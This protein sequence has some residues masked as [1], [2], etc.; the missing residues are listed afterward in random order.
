MTL[1]NAIFQQ[2]SS[3]SDY[4]NNNN[5]I[6]RQQVRNTIRQLQDR[7]VDFSAD[8]G[9]FAEAYVDNN[10]RKNSVNTENSSAVFNINK[11]E[12]SA[13]TDLPIIIIEA[14]SVDVDSFEINDCKCI[15]I[16]TGKW[17]LSC[18]VTS[19]VEKRAK[20]IKTLFYGT[21]GTNP[22]ASSTYI[23]GITAL[24]TNIL[25]DVGKKAIY[26]GI[27][28]SNDEYGEYVETTGTFTNTSTNTDCS[29]WSY[30][31]AGVNSGGNDTIGSSTVNFDGNTINQAH[32]S[33]ASNGNVTSDEMGTDRIADEKDNPVDTMMNLHTDYG[34]N[35]VPV[36]ARAIYLS[37]SD[38]TWVDVESGVSFIIND[39]TDFHASG[40]PLFTSHNES[41][42]ATIEHTLPTKQ[43]LRGSC[44]FKD[45]DTHKVTESTWQ[46]VITKS[47]IDRLIG[48]F[49]LDSHRNHSSSYNRIKIILTYNDSSTVEL[50]TD[51]T[52]SGWINRTLYNPNPNKI[53]ASY[54][55]QI[56]SHYSN[57][58]IEIKNFFEYPRIETQHLFANNMLSSFGTALVEDWE[59]G[60]NIQYKIANDTEDSGWLNYNEISTF[61]PFT[62]EPTKAI[63]KLIPK[64]S[65]P[66]P[67]VP[68]I[69]GFGI[70]N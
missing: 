50:I 5:T 20:I 25:R 39:T 45:Y 52:S 30:C 28:I 9:E 66:T 41:F 49:T 32:P 35:N 21:D 29:V 51:G 22:R 18:T 7:N 23:T 11:Y 10:G 16:G 60:C 13:S 48:G 27:K 8:G 70:V 38:I 67:G 58:Y 46:T 56:Q 26:R 61:T 47:N 44:T 3:S 69:K 62:S 6:L 2:P 43:G 59:E 17:Q 4:N 40:I 57:D 14:E 24:K 31:Y 34:D 36:I 19:N 42:Q 1:T 12:T 64:A 68:S 33:S 37:N 55:V 63:V 15:N 53:V 54:I 65:N